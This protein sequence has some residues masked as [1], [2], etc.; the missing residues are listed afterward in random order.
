MAVLKGLF[1]SSLF[2][3]L[4]GW[5][6]SLVALIVGAVIF[7]F[8]VYIRIL[9]R[10]TVTQQE[11]EQQE[12]L[13][14]KREEV[15]RKQEEYEA[16]R[17]SIPQDAPILWKQDPNDTGRKDQEDAPMLALAHAPEIYGCGFDA[18]NEGETTLIHLPD[19]CEL[20]GQ[21]PEYIP[22][23]LGYWRDGHRYPHMKVPKGDPHA[24]EHLDKLKK[25][26]EER[27]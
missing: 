24:Q 17:L 10:Q 5:Y 23:R 25:D 11:N 19:W 12:E 18:L 26:W 3:F 16:R 6:W 2:V 22:T 14:R 9:E 7:A 13:Q 27:H 21:I 8:Q 1:L 15:E 4:F 20:S